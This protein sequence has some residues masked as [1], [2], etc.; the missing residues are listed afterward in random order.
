MSKFKGGGLE[1]VMQLLEDRWSE[2]GRGCATVRSQGG[3]E[4][5]RM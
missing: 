1:D 4:H 5:M 3:A 2:S